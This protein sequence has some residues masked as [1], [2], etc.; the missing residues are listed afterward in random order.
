[1]VLVLHQLGPAYPYGLRFISQFPVP[2][3][4]GYGFLLFLLFTL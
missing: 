1:M 3:L 2:V 4:L